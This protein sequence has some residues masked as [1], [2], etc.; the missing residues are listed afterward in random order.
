MFG[1]KSSSTLGFMVILAV[2]LF[3][4]GCSASASNQAA[5]DAPPA[6]ETAVPLRI[7]LL[8]PES[9]P[10]FAT[11]QEGGQE[12]ANRLNVDLVIREAGNDIATQNEQI[13]EMIDM[14]VAAIVI[15]AVDST[16]VVE[17]IEAASA[18]GIAILTVDRSVDSDVVIS[19]IASDNAAGGKM[20]GDY[21]AETLGQQGSVVELAGI[22]GTSAA[23]DRGAG[24][25]EAMAT[26]A[27]ITIVAKEIANFNRAEGQTIFAQILA[28]NPNIDGVFAHNDEMILGAIA[29]AEEAG[30]VGDIVFVGFDAVDDAVA[31][32]E[33]GVLNATIAQQP[34]EMGRLGIENAV[35]HLQGE[36]IPANIAVDL[37]LITR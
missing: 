2:Y 8:V 25:N 19:H 9:A 28:D 24:F 16:A 10:F 11:L 36:T 3:F 4:T 21:L 33:T 1:K 20:A 12:A 30:R 5:D 35:K 14:D 34:A 13:Q 23:Q 31:A 26:Y 29:A 32:L 17:Q 18:A 22:S 6:G 37:A 7:A 15:T 27:D